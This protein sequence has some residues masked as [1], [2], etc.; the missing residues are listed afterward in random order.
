MHLTVR[1]LIER[2]AHYDDDVLI[3]IKKFTHGSD[4]VTIDLVEE[5]EVDHDVLFID[6]E[7]HEVIIL[8]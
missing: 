6:G 1:E 4:R 3:G 5:S 7:D 8:G 2:L